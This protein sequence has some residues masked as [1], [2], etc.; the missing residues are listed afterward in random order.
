MI[1]LVVNSSGR[2]RSDV[3][4]SEIPAVLGGE[5]DVLWMDVADPDDRDIELL[6]CQFGFHPL[7]IE[8]ATR[9]HERPKVDNYPGYYFIVFYAARNSGD[10]CHIITEALSLFLGRNFLVSVHRGTARNVADT[11]AR[12]QAPGSPLGNS[13]PVLVH[14][15]LDSMVD[16]Y[17]PLMDRVADRIEEVE[18]SI[19]V[20]FDH[21]AIQSIFDLKKDLLNMRRAVAPERDVL[22]VLLRRELPVFGS[23]DT[24]YLQDVYDH[25]VRVTDSVDTY[26]DLLSSALDSFLSLQSNKL[27]EIMKVLTM[28]SIVL[29]TNAMIAGIYGMNFR[30]MPE[31]GW[32]LGYAWALGCMAVASVAEIWFFRRRHW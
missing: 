27:N 31:L 21:A 14:A 30:F 15:L 19:F 32:P 22:N 5:G 25:I 4:A 1:S 20:S 6:R 29:M 9:E 8:D 2:F 18:D 16:D 10:Q 11:L 28:A 26:R 23:A 13:V 12:W 3:Q 17:F 7:A 24:A